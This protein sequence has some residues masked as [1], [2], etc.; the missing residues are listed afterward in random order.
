MLRLQIVLY[1]SKP[2]SFLVQILPQ[3][4][5]VLIGI[6]KSVIAPKLLYFIIII[7]IK[8]KTKNTALPLWLPSALEMQAWRLG[9]ICVKYSFEFCFAWAPG[10]PT[11][12]SFAGRASGEP[13]KIQ[14]RMSN[15][16]TR[17]FNAKQL[18]CCNQDW[19][20]F[21]KMCSALHCKE[22]CG[23]PQAIKA[24][25]SCSPAKRKR[26][27]GLPGVVTPWIWGEIG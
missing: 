21:L 16:Q 7:A 24:F 6:F 8:K 2:K 9:H 12:T 10:T 19:S 18:D 1:T 22:T 26:F 14:G 15:S 23:S 20:S 4:S 5:G 3:K 17:S 13:K 25:Q 11:E 27:Y